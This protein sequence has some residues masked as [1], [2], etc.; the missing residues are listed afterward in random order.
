MNYRK[1]LDKT[2]AFPASL[3]DALAGYQYLLSLGFEPKNIMLCGDSAGA[4]ACLALARYLDALTDAG[5]HIGQVGALCLLC[6]SC[7]E[8][9]A[10]ASPGPT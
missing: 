2:T 5:H 7:P 4:N 6:V 10:D 8:T 1:S 3:L 9:R